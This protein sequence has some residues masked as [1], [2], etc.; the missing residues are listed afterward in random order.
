[1]QVALQAYFFM[2]FGYD[3][4]KPTN[5]VVLKELKKPLQVFKAIFFTSVVVPT[6]VVSR[7]CF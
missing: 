7:L 6:A 3:I 5:T 4:I 1:L 2:A